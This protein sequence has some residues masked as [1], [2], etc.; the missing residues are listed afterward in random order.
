MERLIWDLL[1]RVTPISTPV[2]LKVPT[3]T[4]LD[5]GVKCANVFYE[6]LPEPVELKFVVN[7]EIKELVKGAE[8][9][10]DKLVGEHELQV[11]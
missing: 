7:D 1:A 9:R 3:I 11:L 8:E 10:F 2:S 5:L 6:G 4:T